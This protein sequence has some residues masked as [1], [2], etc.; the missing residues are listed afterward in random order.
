[1]PRCQLEEARKSHLGQILRRLFIE[2]LA[3]RR[4]AS[5]EEERPR[6]VL[7]PLMLCDMHQPRNTCEV[8]LHG[9]LYI[10][11]CRFGSQRRV[12]LSCRVEE[13]C[14]GVELRDEGVGG[15]IHAVHDRT[16][17]CLLLRL[18]PRHAY[19]SPER[20]ALGARLA[21]REGLVLGDEE[22]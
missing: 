14:E 13:L 7:F 9:K 15:A 4:V 8:R 10:P 18:E 6:V 17:V 16:F 3:L 19:G 22:V 2:V 1:M 12:R 20:F 11:G 5:C 21:A